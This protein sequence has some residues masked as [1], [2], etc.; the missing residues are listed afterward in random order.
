MG[1]V[2]GPAEL[3][4][5]ALKDESLF[6]ANDRQ[7]S[8]G[9][10]GCTSIIA[11]HGTCP[12]VSTYNRTVKLFA[13]W[14]AL[15]APAVLFCAVT[16]MPLADVKPG[17]RG[18]GKTV[19]QGNKVEEFQVEIL[20]VLENLGPKQSI[21]LAR[22]S[23]GPLERTGVMQG[24][25]GSPV[26]IDGKLLGAVAMT[27]AFSKEP[28]AGI[29]PIREMFEVERKPL[30]REQRAWSPLKDP[31]QLLTK[32]QEVSSGLSRL[33]EI[34]TPLNLGGFTRGAVEHFAPQ[35]REYGLEPVQGFSGGGTPTQG[36][37]D[38]QLIQPGSMISVQLL[39]GDMSIGAEGTVT[40][41]EGNSVFGFGHRFLA[42]G[43][44]EMPFARAEV[45]ALL[46]NVQ[47]SFKI[48]AS[49]EW[50]G[51]IT[52]DRSVGVAGYLGKRAEMVPFTVSVNDPDLTPARNMSFRMQM[53]NDRV[54]APLI[55][56]MALYSAIEASERTLGSGSFRVRGQID[57]DGPTPPIRIDNSYTGD[58]NVPLQAS[59]GTAI[60][61]A[62]V[63][64]SGF[65]ALKLKGISLAVD[66]FDRKKQFQIDQVW[67]S[68]REA[69]P[70]D[71][72]ELTTLL[73]GDNG[74]EITR[75]TSY[76]VPVGAPLGT[77]YFTVADAASANMSDYQQLLTGAPRTPVQLVSFLNGLRGND[78]AYVRVWRNE[79]A[80]SVQGQD[81]PDPPPSV[82]MVLAKT[83]SSLASAALWRPSKV[84]EV[85]LSAGDTV[86]TGSKT[87]Q[88]EIKE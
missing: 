52:Q 31:M 55:V 38:P 5:C 37:G 29:R 56:Q 4:L 12:A 72:I 67:T 82:S 17:M 33:I 24:M 36:F 51:S 32:P 80:Y 39:S 25:S 64:Q 21:I 79:A 54:L 16:T 58:F 44:T 45:I 28:I 35:L 27:F 40:H 87:V 69:H 2:R 48:S 65:E 71:T 15:L 88:V 19:F 50:M 6:T 1:E 7:Q 86:V 53:I 8:G 66:S 78:K 47:T 62:Y 70:G 57:F 75:K 23:G 14:S 18:I 26:Y 11:E 9:L 22:L 59:L 42:V 76:K 46:P 83:Q 13:V 43:P 77:L 85:E 34:S 30:V 74:A 60:P 20:G 84:A 3:G 63:M 10:P 61:L 68:R 73:S 81:L 41:V 49:R